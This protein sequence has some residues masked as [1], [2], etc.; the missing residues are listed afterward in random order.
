MA[1]V[2][3][4]VVMLL[5]LAM[6][7]FAFPAAAAEGDDLDVDV[8]SLGPYGVRGAA[9]LIQEADGVLVAIEL[10]GTGVVG[11]HPAH[12]HLG[13]CDGFDPLPSYPLADVDAAGVSRTTVPGV[14]IVDL[15]AE[16]F[17][18]NVHKS[19]AEISTV[20]ACGNLKAPG[21]TGQSGQTGVVAAPDAAGGTA[22][23]GSEMVNVPRAGV[24]SAIGAGGANTA[25]VLLLG[26]AALSLAGWGTTQRRR[27]QR[28]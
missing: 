17:V 6:A 14:T 19:A 20:I 7:G 10:E 23:A 5:G 12:L 2:A 18:V 28:G 22:G 25:I 21:Q 3:V 26:S 13:T 9:V 11:A 8:D 15:L 4:T 16:R 27:E 24:G 1:P